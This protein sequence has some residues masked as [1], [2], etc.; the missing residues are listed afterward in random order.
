MVIF[1][2]NAKKSVMQWAEKKKRLTPSIS[3]VSWISAFAQ[4]H[5][6]SLRAVIFKFQY[7][8]IQ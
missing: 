7:R 2:C 6:T 5:E 8:K 1:V 3:M 4:S